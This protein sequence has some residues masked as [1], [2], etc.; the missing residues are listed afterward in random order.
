M[1]IPPKILEFDQILAQNTSL[2]HTT[3][4]I[5]KQ[6]SKSSLKEIYETKMAFKIRNLM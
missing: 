5:S 1:K 3:A 6:Q 2:D 4:D